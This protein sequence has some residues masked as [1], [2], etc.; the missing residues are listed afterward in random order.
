MAEK[1]KQLIEKPQL[2][3]NQYVEQITGN[4][5]QEIQTKQSQG[6]VLPPRYVAQNALLAAIFKIKQTVDKEKNLALSVCTKDSIQSAVVEMMTKGLDPNKNQCYF[7]VYGD[8]LTL[9]PSYFG[10]LHMAKESDPN[11]KDIYGEVVYDGDT[12]K[13]QIK[14]GTKVITQHEQDI[15]NIDLTKIKGAYATI[16]YRDGHETSEYMSIQQ[17]RNSWSRGTT[18]G[19]TD[20]HELAPE[21]MCK[22]TVLKRLVKSTINT[23]ND[24]NLLT[25]ISEVDEEAEQNEATVPI[26][27]TPKGEYEMPK[28]ALPVKQVEAPK[29]KEPEPV[30]PEPP[31]Q[32]TYTKV[33]ANKEAV[34]AKEEAKKQEPAEEPDWGQMELPDILK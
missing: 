26:D 9:F 33:Q 25:N 28:E 27:I 17:I 1:D 5:M 20:A 2:T 15:D 18:K 12:F 11:I 23:S 6:L 14:S 3:L 30:V 4:I 34:K 22:R 19:N 10:I 29:A 8:K 32:K 31:K 21:E 13:Y 16:V 24:E 7:I